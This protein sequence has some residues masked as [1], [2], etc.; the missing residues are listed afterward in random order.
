MTMSARRHWARLLVAATA[1]A[2][3]A[4]P[5]AGQTNNAFDRGYREGVQRGEQDARSGRE[6]QIERDRI[7]RDGDRGYNN[8][9]GSRDSYR[10]DF[11]R[12]F[13]SGYRSG[14]RLR[15]GVSVQGRR[16]DRGPSPRL[17]GYQEQAFA[18]GY[19]DG[20]RKGVDDGRDRDRYDPARH[21]DYRDADEGYSRSYGSKDAYRNNYRSGFR[22]GYEGGY[23]DGNR[24]WRR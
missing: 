5:A 8:R 7:Y 4:S 16:D 12:G 23:R 14:Y 1:C 3:L 11:R 19:S 22:Q 13:S 18:R 15:V 10:N 20:W 2:V 17:R 9:Y 6:F 24:G 21:G